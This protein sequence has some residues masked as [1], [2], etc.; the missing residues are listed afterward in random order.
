MLVFVLVIGIHRRGR[1]LVGPNHVDTPTPA[2]GGRIAVSDGELLTVSLPSLSRCARIP[3]PNAFP[4]LASAATAAVD[5]DVEGV[6]PGMMTS[7]SSSLPRPVVEKTCNLCE[8][9]PLPAAAAR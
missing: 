1:G 8:V 7:I 9:E 4:P 6:A 2:G 5:V 3:A